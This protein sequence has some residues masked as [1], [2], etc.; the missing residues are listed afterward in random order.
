MD[1]YYDCDIGSYADIIRQEM[2]ESTGNVKFVQK[3]PPEHIFEGIGEPEP[4][5]VEVLPVVL[6]VEAVE[7]VEETQQT[8]AVVETNPTLLDVDH[9][10][11]PLRAFYLSHMAKYDEKLLE[12]KVRA[13]ETDGTVFP[14]VS[15][16]RKRKSCKKETE[17]TSKPKKKKMKKSIAKWTSVE[18][19]LLKRLCNKMIKSLPLMMDVARVF[20]K[21]NDINDRSPRASAVALKKLMNNKKWEAVL[22]I[23][24]KRQLKRYGKV[25]QVKKREKEKVLEE[26]EFVDE[27]YYFTYC[28]DR[29]TG[30]V[31]IGFPNLGLPNFGRKQEEEVW[32]GETEAES[33]ARTHNLVGL[34]EE[35]AYQVIMS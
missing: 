34:T 8:P 26:R 28:V 15:Q 24:R 21:G 30:R 32:R 12:N 9:N 14:E 19:R 27:D 5:T 7:Q 18:L 13:E 3:P 20:S 25:T 10:A 35:Q 2:A 22:E 6:P 29:V 1:H 33:K 11:N 31:N 17:K 16:K 23:E 4:E